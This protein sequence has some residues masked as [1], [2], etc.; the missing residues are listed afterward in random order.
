[1]YKLTEKG[2]KVVK[3]Y[4]AEMEAKRKEILDAGLD[5][6]NYVKIPTIEDIVADIHW[7][8]VDITNQYYNGWCVTDNYDADSPLVLN[9]DEDF[10][11]VR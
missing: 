1:M 6:V 8:G 9:L 2:T 4:I 10:I 7:I 3:D 5:T 11:E